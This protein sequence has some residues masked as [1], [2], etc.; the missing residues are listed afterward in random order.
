MIAVFVAGAMLAPAAHA[1]EKTPT[2]T[3]GEGLAR[4]TGS[5]VEQQQ[6][7]LATGTF[8]CKEANLTDKAAVTG[9]MLIMEPSYSGCTLGGVT[10]TVSMNECKYT[11]E[12]T[13]T[14]E[15][16]KYMGRMG[17]ICPVGGSIK[18]SNGACTVTIEEQLNL[19][20][21]EFENNTAAEPKK[22][23]KWT[24][25]IKSLVYMQTGTCSGGTGIFASGGMMGSETVKGESAVGEPVDLW[26]GD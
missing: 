20:A 26:I 25:N 7:T 4:E 12:P 9:M 2:F 17:V 8:K 11:F 5:Q 10:A 1:E 23:E 14:T 6:F 19:E 3:A 13:S 24:T 16:D 18:I 15:P 22:D 21:V